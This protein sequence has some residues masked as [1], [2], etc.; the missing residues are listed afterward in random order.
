MDKITLKAKLIKAHQE[1]LQRLKD[2]YASYQ[3]DGDLNLE[4]VR[5]A[6]DNS[7]REQTEEFLQAMERQIHQR[8]NEIKQLRDLDFSSKDAVTKGAVALVNGD[9]YIIGIPAC[10]FD[11][12]GKHFVAMSPEAPF[13]RKLMD[14]KENDSFVFNDKMYT[15]ESIF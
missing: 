5:D 9:Y 7:H 12:D 2:E 14:R 8:E 4:D 1:T 11:L 6:D 15:V 13:Y 3:S 10:Q